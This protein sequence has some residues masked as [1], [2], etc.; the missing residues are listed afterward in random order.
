MREKRVYLY[1]TR[2]KTFKRIT[3]KKSKFEVNIE[4]SNDNITLP[5]GSPFINWKDARK[6]AG[7]L[8]H[9]FT[10]NSKNTTILT[11]LGLRK[12]WKPNPIIVKSYDF[13]FLNQLKLKN[14]V[15]ANAFEIENVPYLWEKGKVEQWK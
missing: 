15:L 14:I 12:N 2:H 8:P 13:D 4:H 10:V 3:S 7:P 9:T 5:T 6:F 1:Y 11:I